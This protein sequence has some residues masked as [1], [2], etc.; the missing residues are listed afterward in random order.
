V[1]ITRLDAFAVVDENP[2]AIGALIA[3]V[4][5]FPPVAAKTGWPQG[6]AMSVPL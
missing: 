1:G 4:T 2:V 5:T 6:A 3:A